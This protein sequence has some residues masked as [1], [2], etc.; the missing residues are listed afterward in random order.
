MVVLCSGRIQPATFVPSNSTQKLIM[1]ESDKIIQED[2]KQFPNCNYSIS[3]S[4]S[5]QTKDGSLVCEMM[6]TI[7]RNCPKER[8]VTIYSNK[9]Q[10][11]T[12]PG[13]ESDSSPFPEFGSPLDLFREMERSLGA[14]RRDGTG[15][16]SFNQ[17]EVKDPGTWI[18]F[19]F[20]GDTQLNEGSKDGLLG[21][22]FRQFGVLGDASKDEKK[23]PKSNGSGP[24][25][26]PPG[27]NVGPPEDI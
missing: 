2:R 15:N 16:G 25:Q 10:Y 12:N 19:R 24:P 9:T 1:D 7:N 8:P 23:K 21:S 3:S 18:E 17:P 11:D 26:L 14:Q 13:L 22:I 4:K 27:T 6:K 20:G 5:C